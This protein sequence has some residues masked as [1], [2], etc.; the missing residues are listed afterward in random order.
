SLLQLNAAPEMRGRVMALFA[1]VFLGSTPIGGP[2]V[3]WIAERFGPRDALGLA[4]LATLLTGVVGM[5]GVR[6]SRRRRGKGPVTSPGP[7]PPDLPPA[8]PR[9]SGPAGTRGRRAR[10]PSPEGSPFEGPAGSAPACTRPRRP[11]APPPRLRPPRPSTGAPDQPRVL[12]S[13]LRAPQ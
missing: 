3:G 11:R 5:A 1:L 12:A 10:G 8:R 2:L 4:A 7:E 6:R 9:C 13:G